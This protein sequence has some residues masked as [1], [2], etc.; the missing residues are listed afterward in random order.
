MTLLINSY[1]TLKPAEETNHGRNEVKTQL[2]L[3]KRE[4]KQSD[5]VTRLRL[6]DHLEEKY[7]PKRHL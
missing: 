7:I 2:Q 4:L 6:F 5:N 3:R 1:N